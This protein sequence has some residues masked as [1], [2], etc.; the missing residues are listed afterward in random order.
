MIR[1][2]IEKKMS[3]KN[4][5]DMLINC[6][7]DEIDEEQR[8]QYLWDLS[9]LIAENKKLQSILTDYVSSGVFTR[10]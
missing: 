10:Y 1:E 7:S 4:F 8:F 5:L 2:E 3:E 6:L 9:L